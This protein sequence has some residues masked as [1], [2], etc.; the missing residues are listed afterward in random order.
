M[1]EK[2]HVMGLKISNLNI[3]KTETETYSPR[4]GASGDGQNSTIPSLVASSTLTLPKLDETCLIARWY[5]TRFTVP[6]CSYCCSSVD[7]SF[8][9]SFQTT[10]N[11]KNPKAKFKNQTSKNWKWKWNDN[12]FAVDAFQQRVMNKQIPTFVDINSNN[13]Y[14]NNKK[15]QPL[16]NWKKDKKK[17]LRE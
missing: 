4:T 7:P 13:R 9:N 15:L 10:P 11:K 5:S 16:L 12:K 2:G 6:G 3:I 8:K 14:N 17:L 1:L